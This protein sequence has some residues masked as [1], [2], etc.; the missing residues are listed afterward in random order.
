MEVALRVSFIKFENPSIAMNTNLLI[1]LGLAKLDE[2]LVREF[3]ASGSDFAGK[4]K[5][6]AQVLPEELAAAL[7]DLG[8]EGDRMRAEPGQ[9]P[10]RLAEFTF[11]CGELHA[12]LLAFGQ[13]RMELENV[14]MGP[15][16]V[17]AT[18][19]QASEVEP[20]ARLIEVRDRVFRRVADFTL[21]ALLV[22]LALLT[23]GLV[24][25]LI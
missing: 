18:P 6:A 2:L 21:K 12:Q 19:L 1:D 10:E 16:R 14:V 25:G 24:F 20:L 17:I 5:A 23:L 9:S 22:G 7:R 4:V 15:D 3:G 13:V 11:R 8:Q